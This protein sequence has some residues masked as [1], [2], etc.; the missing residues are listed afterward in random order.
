[1]NNFS[2]SLEKNIFICL[3]AGSYLQNFFIWIGKPV[4]HFEQGIIEKFVKEQ[5]KKFFMEKFQEILKDLGFIV[6][7]LTDKGKASYFKI[8]K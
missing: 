2:A 8:E 6:W 1:M 7:I 5:L 4:R 3:K